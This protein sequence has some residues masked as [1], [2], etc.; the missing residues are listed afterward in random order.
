MKICFWIVYGRNII[1][2]FVLYIED[3]FE[4]YIVNSNILI[5]KNFFFFFEMVCVKF[6]VW[7]LVFF[8]VL[9]FRVECLGF[10]LLRWWVC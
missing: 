6:I 9:R 10:F 2:F 8:S 1:F 4:V 7:F 3:M 5:S